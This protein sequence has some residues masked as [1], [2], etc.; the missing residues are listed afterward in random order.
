MI[1][2][3]A[4]R[5]DAWNN[6]IYSNFIANFLISSRHRRQLYTLSLHRLYGTTV[7]LEFGIF[8]C[9]WKWSGCT[10]VWLSNVCHWGVAWLSFYT[11]LLITPNHMWMVLWMVCYLPHVCI[12]YVIEPLIWDVYLSVNEFEG[13]FWNQLFINWIPVLKYFGSKSHRVVLDIGQCHK[14]AWLF[15]QWDAMDGGRIVQRQIYDTLFK[16]VVI[17]DSDVGKSA[18]VA[19][20]VTNTDPTLRP[21]HATIG[22]LKKG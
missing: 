18:T 16:I 3:Y 10:I 14:K 17:G 13:N 2:A 1:T 12:I 6:K 11:M 4:S 22:K 7:L 9:W 20:F 8:T 19:R 21:Y 5:H 15:L